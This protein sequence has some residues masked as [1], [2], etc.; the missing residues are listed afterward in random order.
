M[1]VDV[2]FDWAG[3]DV[4]DVIVHEQPATAVYRNTVGQIVVRQRDTVG[5]PDPYVV[6]SP[7][8]AER[9]A[10]AIL[11]QARPEEERP[12]RRERA[13]QGEVLPA[14]TGDL[15]TLAA[16]RAHEAAE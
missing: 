6:I 4:E 10:A 7:E 1:N 11:E 8:V 13:C 14:T 3:A 2:D 5:Y 15:V 12:I 9:V 16:A